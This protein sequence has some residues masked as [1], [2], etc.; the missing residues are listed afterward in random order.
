MELVIILEQPI[1]LTEN[2]LFD[3]DDDDK[4]IICTSISLIVP[5]KFKNDTVKYLV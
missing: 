1:F 5:S 3:E 4:K 2:E